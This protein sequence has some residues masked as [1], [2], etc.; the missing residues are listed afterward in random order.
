MLQQTD[1]DDESEYD[2]EGETELLQT[3]P[4]TFLL[5]NLPFFYLASADFLVVISDCPPSQLNFFQNRHAK[6]QSSSWS[7]CLLN[8][9]PN[10]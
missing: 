6:R 8:T 9:L 3:M 7:M 2:G 10:S 1:F 5:P 4:F